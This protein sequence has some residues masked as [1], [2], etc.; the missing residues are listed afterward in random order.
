MNTITVTGRLT[1][2]P[3][4][5]TVTVKGDE[6][7]VCELSV[8]SNRAGRS[9]DADF[10]DVAIWGLRG[11][12]AA[13]HLVKGQLISIAGSMRQDRWTDDEAT[14]R[15]RWVLVAN[16]TEWL[17]KPKDAAQRHRR[18]QR[19]RGGLLI[20]RARAD[21][22]H[23][24]GV[25]PS[26][27]SNNVASTCPGK[28]FQCRPTQTA[29][30]STTAVTST[31]PSSTTPTA[32]SKTTTTTPAPPVPAPGPATHAAARATHNGELP[33]MPN[34]NDNNDFCCPPD[35]GDCCGP[36]SWCCARAGQH[37]HTPTTTTGA[38]LVHPI[39][40]FRVAPGQARAWRPSST[41]SAR[42]LPANFVVAE[43]PDADTA[44]VAGFDNAGWGRDTYVL[45]RLASGLIVP[46]RARRAGPSP[47]GRAQRLPRGLPDRC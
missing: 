7:K 27:A 26:L 25:R 11:E 39:R 14:K 4:L 23:R 45:P 12:A 15:S 43:S 9:D 29:A 18:P 38:A 2:P 5:K 8:A 13:K 41:E 37:H 44:L 47:R 16:D 30:S 20:P 21:L 1:Q 22:G 36:G 40:T 28:D 6:R 35:S 17:N 31:T 19:G 33:L 10:F 3:V 24:S 34:H 46:L 32:V 42:Y